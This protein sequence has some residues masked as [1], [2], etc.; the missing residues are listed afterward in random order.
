MSFEDIKF[1][2]SLTDI[3][4]RKGVKVSTIKQILLYMASYTNDSQF[5]LAGARIV[6]ETGLNK[7]TVYRTVKWIREIGLIKDSGK[8]QGF[9]NQIIVYKFTKQISVSTIAA[10]KLESY[11]KINLSENSD[12][13]LSE[14]SDTKREPKDNKETSCGKEGLK[15][16]EGEGFLY[17][18]N[19]LKRSKKHSEM[20]DVSRKHSL[21]SL[22]CYHQKLLHDIEN[23][24]SVTLGALITRL[25][26]SEE[27][28]G[29]PPLLVK[30]GGPKKTTQ[31]TLN[32]LTSYSSHQTQRKLEM[33]EPL[34]T[35]DPEVCGNAS[36]EFAK[37][38]AGG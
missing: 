36:A 27:W 19:V 22:K 35:F 26:T 11:K 17:L 10:S 16:E 25:Q 13:N 14:N 6:K 15:T 29:K 8:R 18:K 24:Q 4:L 1:V 30:N 33:E 38:C 7:D 2:N 23:G 12:T 20:K 5:W 34:K 37:I 31:T 21:H 9:N 3:P 28:I 32:L